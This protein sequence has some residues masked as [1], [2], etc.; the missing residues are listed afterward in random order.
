MATTELA[1]RASRPTAHVIVACASRKTR[2]AQP[3]LRLEH[4]LGGSID[5]VVERWSA[6]LT[7]A[8][9]VSV[10]ARDL[11]AG[12]HWTV[13]KQLADSAPTVRVWVCS[14]GYGLVPLDAQIRSYD[15]TFASG[16]T[17]SV[18]GGGHGRRTWWSKLAAWAGPSSGD[19]RSLKALVATAPETPVLVALPSAYLASCADDL[20]EAAR[21]TDR[22]LVVGPDAI[23]LPESRVRPIRLSARA[24][25]AMGGSLNSLHSRAAFHLVARGAFDVDRARMVID[26]LNAAM[27]A[28]PR[29]SRLTDVEIR[30]FIDEQA[31][32]GASRT[33]LLSALRSSGRACGSRRFHDLFDG[34]MGERS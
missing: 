24:R 27:V 16:T 23:G 25:G 14:A 5:G 6:A 33:G 11:Y 17:N 2:P 31:T 29:R 12:E 8:S 20:A 19:P 1:A 34:V 28:V 13:V 18:P 4:H 9:D 26:D 10:V 21:L 3:E 15:A 32:D 30:R 22:L 7:D